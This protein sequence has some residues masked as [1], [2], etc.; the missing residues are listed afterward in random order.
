MTT[1]L[2]LLQDLQT[3]TKEYVAKERARLTNEASVLTAVLNG[4]MGGKGI[5]AVSTAVVSAVA[6]KSLASYLEGS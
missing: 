2:A 4:R 3:T 1:R 6:Q 5:Q